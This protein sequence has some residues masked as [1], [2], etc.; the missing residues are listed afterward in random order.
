MLEH[1]LTRSDLSRGLY[2]KKGSN[3]PFDQGQKQ[4]AI[5]KLETFFL[6][7]CNPYGIEF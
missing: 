5:S 6:M 2:P 7:T 4:S 3:L 1:S